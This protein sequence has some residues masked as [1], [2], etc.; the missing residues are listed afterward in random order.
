MIKKMLLATTIALGTLVTTAQSVNDNGE[1]QFPLGNFD[2][3]VTQPAPGGDTTDGGPQALSNITS[4]AGVPLVRLNNGVMMPRFGLGT[5]VQSMEGASQRQ[6]LNE[7]V[8]GMVISAL[9]SGYRHLDDAMF[10]YN[11]R[12]AGWGIRESGVPREK[13][14]VTSKISGDLADAQNAFEGMLE[15]LQVDY[16]DLVYIHHPAG[17]LSDILACWRVME[18]EYK[19]GRIRALGISNFDNRME[20]FNY[21]MENSE[22]K[23]QVAQIECHPLAQRIEARQLYAENYDIQVECWYP[24]NHNRGDVSNSTLQQIA[25]AHDKTVYQIILCWHMQE[26]LCP[27]PGSTNPAHILENISIFDFE[28]S[29]E[30]MSAIRAIDLGDAGRSFNLSYGNWGFGNFQDYTY[31]HTY[32]P[33]FDETP[34]PES[35]DLGLSV[36]WATFNVGATSPTDLGGLYGWGD[37]T[38]TNHSENNEEYPSANPPASICGSEYDIATKMWGEEWRMPSQA[39]MVELAEKCTWEWTTV[40]GIAG[41]TVTGTNGNS[42]FLPAAA[43]RTG[44]TISN[45]VGQRG[46]YWSGTLWESDNNFASYLY[47]YDN[48]S[49]V[50]PERSNRRYIG[51]SVRPVAS[52]NAGISNISVDNTNNSVTE[53][54]N[55]NGQRVYHVDNLKGIYIVKDSKGTHK[56]VF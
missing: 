33:A 25:T 13:I 53:I 47:F 9:Q 43:S 12:G 44:E 27:V 8:R 5:Q 34:Q 55:L 1:S 51:M 50:Q 41:M 49:R 4:V 21:I 39:E 56:V 29:D 7:T 42:I 3:E 11:E 24:L 38:G 52:E 20:A 28:L 31:D 48:A 16:L 23:P 36:K 40:D 22:I 15:R 2:H 45:Q 10:Y 18:K 46:C 14:W 32:E 35:V 6:Q 37:A 30:E 19:A 26:G 54:Y 17:T